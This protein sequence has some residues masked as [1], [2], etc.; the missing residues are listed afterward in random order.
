MT[1]VSNV[2]QNVARNDDGI[3]YGDQA[4]EV[5]YPADGHSHC[6]AVEES[7]FWFAHRNACIRAMVDRYPPLGGGPIVD[8]GGGNGFV[9]R[10]LQNAGYETILLEPGIVGARNAHA[11][12]VG[13]VVCAT[14]EEAGALPRSIPALGLFDVVEHIEDD[15]AFLRSVRARLVEGGRLY[16]TVP[17]HMWL[18]SQDDADAGHFRRYT[19]RSLA[20]LLDASGFDIVFLSGYFRWLPAPIL[21]M[22]VAPYHLGREVPTSGEKVT[23]DHNPAAWAASAIRRALAPEVRNI[24]NGRS[25]RQGASLIVCASAR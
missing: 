6:F 9:A 16:A 17:A 4:G 20:A 1:L 22:R 3:W 18:W 10:G 5:S 23:K 11:R 15:R 8:L 12:G 19:R 14:L 2:F 13:A 24:A 25:M 7:S 21:L